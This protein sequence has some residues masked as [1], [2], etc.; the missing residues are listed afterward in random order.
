[1]FRRPAS[2]LVPMLATLGL[3]AACGTPTAS[4]PVTA[5]ATLAP[6]GAVTP[7]PTAGSVRFTALPHGVRVVGEVRGLA[8]NSEHGFHIHEKGDCADNGNAA[9]GHFNAGGTVHGRFDTPAS[10]AG[11]LPS[12]RAGDDGTA[13]IDVEAHAISLGTG[14][15]NDV[16]G[17]ALVVH[18]DRDDFTSQPAGNSGPRLACAV[19]TR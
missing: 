11:D 3:L 19:I 12:L 9:G 15:D 1:M 16:L 2:L 7:N 17:R 18:R 13:R 14:A 5:V 4:R 8:P 6:T 10:H